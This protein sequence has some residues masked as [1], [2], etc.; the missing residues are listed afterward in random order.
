MRAELKE[1]F[2]DG[3]YLKDYQPD[4]P[5]CFSLLVRLQIGAEREEASDSFEI[6]LCTPEWIKNASVVSPFI[7]GLFKLIVPSYDYDA[8]VNYL[9]AYCKNFEGDDWDEIA[10]RLSFFGQ[11]EFQGASY[12]VNVG[13]P[14]K[15]IELP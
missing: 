11:W 2:A 10:T 3:K 7:S 1:L 13:L 14:D 5:T 15:S 8:L 9:D 12:D 6:T 4:N